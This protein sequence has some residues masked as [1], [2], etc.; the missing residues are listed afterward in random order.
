MKKCEYVNVLTILLIS[1]L[2]FDPRDI[3]FDANILTV[4]TGIEEHDCYAV[5]FIEAVREIKKLCPGALTSGGISNLSFSFRG[6]N[7]VR[8]AMHSVFLYHAIKAGLDMGIVNAGML[9]V[10]DELNPVLREK[11]EAVVLNKHSNATEELLILAESLKNQNTK[12]EDIIEEWR[13]HSVEA[14]I[15]HSLVKGVDTFIEIDTEE[16][17]I[18][19]GAPLNV[20]EGPLMSAMKIVGGLFGEGKMFLP[21]VV[22]SARVMKKAVAYLEPFM[23]ASEDHQ[24]GVFVIAT[25]KG[26]VHDIGKNI[27]AVVLACNG[28]K[29]IDLGVMVSCQ[30]ILE[31]AIRLKADVIGL[32]GLITPSLDEMIHN[33]KEMERLG[34]KVPL[35]IGG[36]TTSRAHTA[37]KISPHYN[38]PIVHVGD[39][40]LVIEVCN[41][42]LSPTLHA[43]Y[44]KQ[45]K[46][47]YTEIRERFLQR[48]E[49][50]TSL[51]SFTDSQERKFKSNWD[52]LEISQPSRLGV[53]NLEFTLEEII[54]YIDWSPFFW[55][56]ELKGT[57]PKILGNTTYGHEAQKIF[58]DAQILLKD[59][60]KNKRFSP[61]AVIGIFEAYSINEDVVMYSGEKK[62]TFH[63]LRQQKEKLESNNSRQEFN[64]CLSDYIAPQSTGIKDYCGGFAVTTGHEVEEF[65]KSFQAKN[66][67]YSSIMV[68]ALADRLAEALAE[69]AHKKVR[70]IFTFGQSENL[71]PDDLIK[72][73][74]RGIRPAPG[75]PACPD[76]TEKEILWQI[77]D[78]QKNTGITLTESFAMNPPSSV[79]GFYFNHPQAKYFAVGNIDKDQIEDYAKRKNSSISLIE[80]WLSPNLNYEP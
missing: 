72:E 54:P 13:D 69:L 51:L 62:T 5:N 18:K 27:V 70:D 36:A 7:L 38:G 1:N 42:L 15:A 73:K 63:F 17:R 49:T 80:K 52:K 8:E 28:Y 79:S 23:N 12:K 46:I 19:Y 48:Q 16:A 56:W 6:N 71:A 74:Y 25:V 60:V 26:D 59:I 10:Y 3:I 76:H 32:S 50:P 43:D 4:A 40:S 24:Q 2:Q 53:F 22:K 11:C 77:L 47:N 30:K 44:V 67:D 65:A 35:L 68:K 64:Y 34:L 66:D 14:R 58:D 37:I 21:Q 61:K 57:Y 20:I 9:G 31:E 33:A 55:T 41:K 78:A 45:L 75:Y 39:A 29:V